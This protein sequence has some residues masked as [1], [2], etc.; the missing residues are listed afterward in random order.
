ML[1][2]FSPDHMTPTWGVDDLIRTP[3]QN[4]NIHIDLFAHLFL[5]PAKKLNQICGTYFNIYTWLYHGDAIKTSV[6]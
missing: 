3:D 1:C 2:D 5:S 6:L 4:F